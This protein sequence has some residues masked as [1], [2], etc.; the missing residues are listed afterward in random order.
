MANRSIITSP[1]VPRPRPRISV[2]AILKA[3]GGPSKLADR[4]NELTPW[5]PIGC[6]AITQWQTRRDGRIPEFRVP[7]VARITGIPVDIL[8]P[9]AD[10]I[11]VDDSDDSRIRDV[12][13]AA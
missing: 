13:D 12:A 5:Y 3:G 9:M 7:V 2:E 10:G 6:S 1:I 8:W 4:I 11:P